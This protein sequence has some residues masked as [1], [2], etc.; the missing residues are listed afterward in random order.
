[1]RIDGKAVV[2]NIILFFLVST[3]ALTESLWSPAEWIKGGSYALMKYSCHVMRVCESACFARYWSVFTW[4]KECVCAQ[5]SEWSMLPISALCT[6]AV[7]WHC[8]WE[9]YAKGA[10]LRRESECSRARERRWERLAR[11]RERRGW[12]ERAGGTVG[13]LPGF[14]SNSR[15]RNRLFF[16]PPRGFAF[17]TAFSGRSDIPVVVAERNTKEQRNS[18][19]ERRAP[20]QPQ[21]R[22]VGRLGREAERNDGEVESGDEKLIGGESIRQVIGK[23]FWG[24]LNCTSTSFLW[25]WKCFGAGEEL[26]TR[27]WRRKLFGDVTSASDICC[28]SSPRT[29]FHFRSG[30]GICMKWTPDD[31]DGNRI[32]PTSRRHLLPP[33]SPP[34]SHPVPPSTPAPPRTCWNP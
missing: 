30:F 25:T 3:H 2:L 17:S 16:P 6:A 27:A 19:E 15:S 1:M 22:G 11:L 31:S 20:A 23:E 24:F 26:R 13:L 7:Y 8:V 9:G 33:I 21:C 32:I 14:P 10:G 4:L 18:G 28:L 34:I 29:W 12:G 5:T